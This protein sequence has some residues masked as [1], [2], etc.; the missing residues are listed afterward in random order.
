[1]TSSTKN[2]PSVEKTNSE[3]TKNA[4]FAITD[5]NGERKGR[6]NVHISDG[7]G[8]PDQELMINIRVNNPD[9]KDIDASKL[10]SDAYGTVKK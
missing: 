8:N 6:I 5:K 7:Q 1:M 3:I 10:A 9:N 2:T 4:N